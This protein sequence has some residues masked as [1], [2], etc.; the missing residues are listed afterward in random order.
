MKI[1]VND[2]QLC[3]VV[4]CKCLMRKKRVLMLTI[5]VFGVIDSLSKCSNN[6][7]QFLEFYS[8]SHF[9][10]CKIYVVSR[11]SRRYKQSWYQGQSTR[12]FVSM[13]VLDSKQEER[14]L[15]R[16]RSCHWRKLRITTKNTPLQT[17]GY[18]KKIDENRQDHEL[19][20]NFRAP[21]WF[22]SR[23]HQLSRLS[24]M[25]SNTPRLKKKKHCYYN[26]VCAYL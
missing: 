19:R 13:G 20:P 17:N 21:P 7:K 11:T 2:F 9:F 4:R 12:V 6:T 15:G 5:S 16:G 14:C 22:K 23:T 25:L 24:P 18:W 8:R 1:N 26:F 3:N 10:F